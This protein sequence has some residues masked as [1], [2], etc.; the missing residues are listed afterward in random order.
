[1]TSTTR[2]RE[3]DGSWL[4]SKKVTMTT[5][6]WTQTKIDGEDFKKPI[7]DIL[8]L[9]EEFEAHCFEQEKEYNQ[10]RE[11]ATGSIVHPTFP[12][13]VRLVVGF[14][15][16]KPK[17]ADTLLFDPM[18]T[19][20]F[21]KVSESTTKE[22]EVTLTR[23]DISGLRLVS[24]V[25]VSGVEITGGRYETYEEAREVLKTIQALLL[26]ESKKDYENPQ[27]RYAICPK[28]NRMYQWSGKQV[29]GF[30]GKEHNIRLHPLHKSDEVISHENCKVRE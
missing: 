21:L 13:Q 24:G 1:M 26:V 20:W 18:P 25:I 6:F 19:P 27:T 8:S 29:R 15:N 23:F 16:S 3:K 2:L 10:H 9:T 14:E 22:P 30:E 28:C 5:A 7:H 11:F 4:Y 12:F 17:L